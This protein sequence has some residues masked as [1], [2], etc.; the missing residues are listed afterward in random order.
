MAR[1]INYRPYGT[2]Y[3]A[4]VCRDDEVILHGGVNTGKTLNNFMRAHLYAMKYPGSRIL[5]VRKALADLVRTA[6]ATYEDVILPCPVEDPSCPV[7]LRTNKEGATWYQY[8]ENGSRI[9]LGGMN[10]RG[11]VLSGE[12]DLVVTVQTEEFE[13]EDWEYFL[14]RIGRGA[15]KN[16]PYAMVLGDA[17]PHVLGRMHWIMQRKTVKLFKLVRQDNPALYDQKTKKPNEDGKIIESRLDRL[18]GTTAKRLRDGLWVGSDRL[19]YPEFI[20]DMHLI[21]LQ[22][23]DSLDIK[24][25][26][27]YLGMD[28]GY[29]DPASLSLYGL[30]YGVEAFPQPR[31]IQ[32]RQTYRVQELTDFWKKRAL[33]YQRWVRRYFNGHITKMICDKSRPEFIEE[34]RM[35][36]LPAVKTD[37]GPGSVRENIN[38]VK[39]RLDKFSLF[40]V[41]SN[42]DTRD[43]ILESQHKPLG[44]V[45]E[46]SR[47]EN[48]K[49]TRLMRK[50]P[51]PIGENHGLDELGYV[52][53]DL[54]IPQNIGAQIDTFTGDDVLGT[55]LS[56]DKP[57]PEPRWRRQMG[58]IQE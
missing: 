47:Y 21:D 38:A 14:T 43:E 45:D 41:R 56:L 39:S 54:H 33:A 25:E 46:M 19:V 2:G 18:T 7:R 24:I 13:E 48:P 16:G 55:R 44:T 23:F 32:I 26:K 4:M 22:D 8:K 3:Q 35:A 49:I 27:W 29:D 34:F 10:N 17:N 6:V 53:R 5:F 20:E 31:L 50:M 40:F 1:V 37:G 42:L 11:S 12:Y 57:V 36:G 52:C 9:F 30:T 15:G 58:L 51:D 28:W